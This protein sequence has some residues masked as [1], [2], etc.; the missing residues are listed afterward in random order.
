MEITFTVTVYM[1]NL[2]INIEFYNT[3]VENLFI[4]FYLYI[5]I[6]EIIVL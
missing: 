5:N 6:L 1:Y 4:Y 3:I 2:L